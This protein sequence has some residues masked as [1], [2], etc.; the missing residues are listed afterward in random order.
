MC[1][2]DGCDSDIVKNLLFAEEN[3]GGHWAVWADNGYF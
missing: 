3:S 1:Q 2:E